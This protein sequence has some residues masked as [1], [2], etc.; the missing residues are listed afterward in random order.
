MYSHKY[1]VQLIFVNS[2]FHFGG[3]GCE[4]I[5]FYF[6]NWNCFI[7]FIKPRVFVRL[8]SLY[9]NIKHCADIRGTLCLRYIVI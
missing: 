4:A 9:K 8:I 6:K 7:S 1:F 5:P 3:F 2:L